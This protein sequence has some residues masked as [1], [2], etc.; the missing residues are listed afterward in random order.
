MASNMCSILA[1]V[2]Q[3]TY[4]TFNLERCLIDDPLQYLEN[5]EVDKEKVLL[6]GIVESMALTYGDEKPYSIDTLVWAS[7]YFVLT[8][9]TY[10]H[11]KK[12]LS[13]TQ[14]FHYH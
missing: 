5:L 9:S 10:N 3:S 7:D 11:L 14:Y 12:R 6:T 4:R 13:G 8:Q 2:A 1:Q